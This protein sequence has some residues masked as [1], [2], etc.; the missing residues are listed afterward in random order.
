MDEEKL[1]VPGNSQVLSYL[2]LV[3][4]PAENYHKQPSDTDREKTASFHE[5]LNLP[6][7][8]WFK[9]KAFFY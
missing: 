3:A 7:F 1:R 9:S 5:Y 8:A 6:G 4:P 2:I